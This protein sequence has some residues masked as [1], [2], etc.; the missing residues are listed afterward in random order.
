M[1]KQKKPSGRKYASSLSHQKLDLKLVLQSSASKTKAE[2]SI[3]ARQ[4]VELI[5]EILHSADPTK[6]V[7]L[8]V[9][10]IMCIRFYCINDF[11]DELVQSGI[12]DV[13]DEIIT[14]GNKDLMAACAS[15]IIMTIP[16]LVDNK[17]A[18][19][20]QSNCF[21]SMMG[22]FAQ[23]FDALGERCALFLNSCCAS[24]M[25]W[26][27]YEATI[28]KIADKMLT[29][30]ERSNGL[31]SL[32]LKQLWS[33]CNRQCKEEILGVLLRLHGLCSRDLF[34]E[35]VFN[36]NLDEMS[37]LREELDGESKSAGEVVDVRFGREFCC[38][39]HDM[40]NYF[41]SAIPEKV[42]KYYSDQIALHIMPTLG[43]FPANCSDYNLY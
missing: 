10:I 16:L 19:T 1:E 41:I 9:H 24:M 42:Q 37:R 29:A 14:F 36:R 30:M 39:M 25:K 28:M 32:M 17:P 15:E 20:I 27:N 31:A 3:R 22:F 40:E 5:G 7:N 11:T 23:S 34:K 43:S 35:L 38:L 26:R 8:L 4:L 13:Y 21:A 12:L 33:S 6:H 2:G 18:V